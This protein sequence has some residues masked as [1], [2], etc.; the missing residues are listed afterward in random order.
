M[1]PIST[2]PADAVPSAILGRNPENPGGAPSLHAHVQEAASAS[3]NY[4]TGATGQA[5]VTVY[6]SEQNLD[7][8]GMV[9]RFAI[10]NGE[11]S[12][13]PTA[14][15]T[16]KGVDLHIAGE[17]EAEAMIIALQTALVQ[18]NADR[19]KRVGVQIS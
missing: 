8:G 14:T 2:S 18:L 6:R 3:L 12:F 5:S 4:A 7:R 19:A 15:L 9:L 1:S 10:E 16:P 17:A 11:S 13:L